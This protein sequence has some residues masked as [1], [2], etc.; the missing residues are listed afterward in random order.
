[1]FLAPLSL[2][3]VPQGFKI[4]F[5][6][7]WVSPLG[8]FYPLRFGGDP[9]YPLRPRLS[10]SNHPQNFSDLH[11]LAYYLGWFRVAYAQ[12]YGGTRIHEQKNTRRTAIFDF[13][14][15]F[16]S[17]KRVL[18]LLDTAKIFEK[19]FADNGK[20]RFQ[21]NLHRFDGLEPID[22][23]FEPNSGIYPYQVTDVIESTPAV[24]H[25]FF[26]LDVRAAI[27]AANRR[28]ANV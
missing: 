20:I 3:H 5:H 9:D 14:P 25:Q 15:D 12:T 16:I 26:K 27:A 23:V 17:N 22:T 10:L 8:V 2:L 18:S 4:S 21:L 13:A 24:S 28:R 6:G 11:Q 19:R 7:G 1:M